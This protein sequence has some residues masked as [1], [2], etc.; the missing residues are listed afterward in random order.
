M[1]LERSV[2]INAPIDGV[3]PY[4][5]AGQRLLT[6][7]VGFSRSHM[8]FVS[9]NVNIGKIF[10]FGF[11][12]LS[13]G[14]DDNEGQPANPYDLRAEWGPS[15]YSDIRQRLLLGSSLPLPLKFTVNPFFLV[16]SGTPY[17]ITTGIDTNGDGF[18]TERPAL[19]AGL[20]AASCSGGS[21]VYTAGFG[22][23][24]PGPGGRRGDHRAELR[25]RSGDN[26]SGLAA[27]AYVVIRRFGRSWNYPA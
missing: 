18:A 8:L 15:S 27:L 17:D 16:Q 14:M 19:M 11:Y 13:Y 20:N 25:A 22:C 2:D 4:G 12:G 23:L 7:S 26:Q 3:S 24:Q 6:E 5:E 21:L 9:P 10:L 1:H